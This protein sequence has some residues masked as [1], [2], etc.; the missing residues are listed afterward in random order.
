MAITSE[1]LSDRAEIT[2]VINRYGRCVTERDLETM[3]GLFTDDAV[4]DSYGSE[5]TEGI[6][7]IRRM[8]A[9]SMRPSPSSPPPLPMDEHIVST[10]LMTNVIIDLEGDTAKVE[11][12]CLAAHAG[13]RGVSGTIL[14]RGMRNRDQFRRTPQGWKIAHRVHEKLWS[15]EVPGE[16]GFVH[17]TGA[18]ASAG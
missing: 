7:A 4:M 8:F 17:R 10:P 11:S 2:E 14:L 5:P 1:E 13:R 16:S 15:A 18:V 9:A 12:L 3:V 6:E